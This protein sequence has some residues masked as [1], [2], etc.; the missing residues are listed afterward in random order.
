M[1]GPKDATEALKWVQ[2]AVQAGRYVPSTHFYERLVERRI[3]IQ[4]IFHAVEMAA[5]C[6][7]YQGTPVTDVEENA[8]TMKCECGGML[9]AEKL[10]SFDFT[11]LAGIPVTLVDVPGL[12]C[13]KCK[14]ATLEG[15]VINYVTHALASAVVRQQDRLS[16]EHARYLRKYLRLTQQALAGRMGIARETVADWERGKNVISPQHD[17]ML[18]AI[19]VAQLMARPGEGPKRRDMVEAIRGARIA[20][21]PK[22]VLPPVVIDSFL[23]ELRP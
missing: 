9:K 5:S 19:V 16:S 10:D 23:K 21:P 18:R 15:E 8:M 3:D 1:P 7:E 12:R 4:D 20:E 13:S 14:G 6:A 2:D 17:L 22:G 11:P